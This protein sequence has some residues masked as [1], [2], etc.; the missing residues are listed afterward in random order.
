MI[1]I[2]SVTPIKGLTEWDC[3]AMIGLKWTCRWDKFKLHNYSFNIIPGVH[4][5][6]CRRLSGTRISN[7]WDEVYDQMLI[8]KDDNKWINNYRSE[9]ADR[10]E[11]N[12]IFPLRTQSRPVQIENETNHTIK[13]RKIQNS[14]NLLSLALEVLKMVM[15]EPNWKRHWINRID[16]V[17]N[18]SVTLIILIMKW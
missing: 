8:G 4:S 11:N 6:K 2:N 18:C 12:I 17:S 15:A 10:C 7:N 16:R 14:P 13:L 9:A 5:E 3:R 1:S